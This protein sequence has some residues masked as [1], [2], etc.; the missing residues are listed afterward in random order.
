MP[1]RLQAR[2]C[3]KGNKVADSRL[4]RGERTP[5]TGPAPGAA[6]RLGVHK[7]NGGAEEG[8]DC[9]TTDPAALAKGVM[10]S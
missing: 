5:S 8:G 7:A 10:K 2:P 9:F 4:H 1:G 3:G 6:C